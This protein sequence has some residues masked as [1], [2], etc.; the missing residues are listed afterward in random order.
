MVLLNTSFASS[1]LY[2][3]K[4][5]E[6]DPLPHPK[7]VKIEWHINQVANGE[8]EIWEVFQRCLKDKTSYFDSVTNQQG[9]KNK[10]DL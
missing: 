8:V 10:L 5:T 7:S 4:K 9:F 2:G 1:D 3:G 6:S